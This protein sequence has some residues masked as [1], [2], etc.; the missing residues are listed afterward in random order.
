M[1]T[2]HETA[3]P[4]NGAGR[5]PP[6]AEVAVAVD[7]IS[8]VFLPKN[9]VPVPAMVDVS[10]RI[11]RKE[12]LAILGPSGCGKS[13]LL[14]ILGGLDTQYRGTVTWAQARQE[15]GRLNAAT[16]FQ[17]DST[18][19]WMTVAQNIGLGLSG[20]RLD[21][22]ERKER[23]DRYSALV[24]LAAFRSAYPHE[25]SGGMKQR[26]AIAR[27]LA[28]EPRVL[29]MDEPLAALDAQTRLVMQAE[30]QALWRRTES[31]VVYVTHDIEE[32]ITLA[33]RIV[34]MSARPGRIKSERRT[35]IHLDGADGA[36]P[37]ALRAHPGFAPL[38]RDL[39]ADLAQEV[40]DA[41]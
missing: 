2:A 36:D 3:V 25:L 26:A 39:W 22:A 40:G 4:G 6:E 30:L 17:Q 27:A 35:D 19:P 13:T 20:L 18:L 21:A 32:A 7:R 14:R 34:V 9:N 16:V 41:L 5:R 11:R 1:T 24:G 29:L 38:A 8:K 23:I 31:T 28:C 10:L 33:D 15:H 12:V 37:V